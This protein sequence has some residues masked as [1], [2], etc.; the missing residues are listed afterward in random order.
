MII[1]LK[2]AP[3]LIPTQAISLHTLKWNTTEANGIQMEMVTDVDVAGIVVVALAAAIGTAI[4]MM[5]HNPAPMN[6][7]ASVTLQ[8]I[9]VQATENPVLK[10][11]VPAI[12][13][14]IQLMWEVPEGPP[15]AVII[16]KQVNLL[17]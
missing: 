5:T 1:E 8:E 6:G 10:D 16:E 7:M 11:K 9:E 13:M 15:H 3:G 4:E 12:G 14:G 17:L 2:N